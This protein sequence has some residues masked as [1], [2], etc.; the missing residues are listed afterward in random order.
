MAGKIPVSI[1]I[2]AYNGAAF[3]EESVQSA[4][5]QTYKHIEILIVDDGSADDTVAIARKLAQVH[6]QIRVEE[7]PFNL[8]LAGN[9]M[10]CIELAQHKWIK[11]LFQDDTLEKE[12][13]EH[14]IAAAG[15]TKKQMVLCARRFIVDG[16]ASDQ[17]KKYFQDINKPENI[18]PN[19]VITSGEVANAIIRYE[20]ENIL[21][22]PV[23]LLFNK[24]VI[25]A[26]GGFDKRF[27]Q[28]VDFDFVVRV[29]LNNGLVFV[30]E[31]MVNFRVHMQSQSAANAPAGNGALALPKRIRT[32]FG[33]ALL[34][35]KLLL[36]DSRY[37]AVK[38]VWPHDTLL[39]FYMH[40]YLKACKRFGKKNVRMALEDVWSFLPE[41]HDVSYRYLKYKW[42]KYQFK[43]TLSQSAK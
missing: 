35:V 28:L 40:L 32:E 9:W 3:L 8:G 19:E 12:C 38:E 31:P 7:N 21:G 37:R 4:L 41:L 18:F 16:N 42:V 27:R 36:D 17:N 15:K 6:P 34:L 13:V 11:F 24:S 26:F 23:C 30:R 25:A 1:C 10:R 14:M 43:Q 29:A 22:E 5:A 20:T 33:D 39:L 2:P